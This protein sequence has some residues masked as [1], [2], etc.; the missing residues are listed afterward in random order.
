MLFFLS[1]NVMNS[2][3]KPVNVNS[4]QQVRVGA[5]SRSQHGNVAHVS[6]LLVVAIT[7]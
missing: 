5:L 1:E 7:S 2:V 6:L 4:R 3:V